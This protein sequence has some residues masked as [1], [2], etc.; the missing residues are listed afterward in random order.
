VSLDLVAKRRG[1][2]AL[3]VNRVHDILC[4]ALGLPSP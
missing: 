4:G 3:G 1:V 2:F